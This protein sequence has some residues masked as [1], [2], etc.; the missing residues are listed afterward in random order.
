ATWVVSAA[1]AQRLMRLDAVSLCEVT[2]ILLDASPRHAR[3]RFAGPIHGTAAG[4][5]VRIE[6]RGVALVDRVA[7]RV[8]RCHLAWRET[9][10]RGPATPALEATAKLN[11]SIEPAAADGLSAEQLALAA[12]APLDSRLETPVLAG[13]WTM[14]AERDWRVIDDSAAGTTLRRVA[15][16]GIA[17]QTTLAALPRAAGSIELLERDV[18]YSLGDALTRVI[19]RE[20]TAIAAGVEL[21]SVASVGQIDGQPTAWRHYHLGTPSAAV[22]ATTTT[23]IGD[24]KTPDDVAPATAWVRT[25]HPVAPPQTAAGP[26]RAAAAALR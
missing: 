23:P 25:L 8:E 10:A 2:G 19:G 5:E 4:A 9:R 16:D 3:L 11:L 20:R 12:A 15:A 13:R 17:A 26:T 7:G 22:A 1:D 18:R 6:L 21:V 24:A 14:L